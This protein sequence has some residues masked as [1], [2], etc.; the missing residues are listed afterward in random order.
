MFVWNACLLIA[1]AGFLSEVPDPIRAKLM[2]TNETY[3]VF[4]QTKTATDGK[5]YVTKGTYC[6]RPGVDFTWRTLEPFETCFTASTTNYVYSNEDETV[7]RKLSDLPGFSRFE[8]V[9]NGD[10]SAF[11]KAFDALYAEE[12]GKFYVR[13]KPKTAELKRVLSRVDAESS[14][15]AQSQSP[16]NSSASSTAWTSREPSPTGPSAPSLPTRPY[17]RSASERQEKMV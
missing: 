13:A 6:I 3:G 16:P 5:S 15:C 8:G 9:G 2:S 4:V 7:V 14:T 17:S 12:A 10:F 1:A 11:F